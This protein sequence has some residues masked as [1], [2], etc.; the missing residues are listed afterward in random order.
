MKH[1]THIDI[2]I[3]RIATAFYLY[4]LLKEQQNAKPLQ[5]TRCETEECEQAAA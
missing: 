5:F 3:I 4:V 2:K 1:I